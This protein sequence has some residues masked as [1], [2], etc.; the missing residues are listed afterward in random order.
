MGHLR[1]LDRLVALLLADHYA[2]RLQAGKHVDQRRVAHPHRA[3]QQRGTVA[4]IL[5][6]AGFAVL[7]EVPDPLHQ[8]RE[9][10]P[11]EERLTSGSVHR[12]HLVVPLPKLGRPLSS[13]ISAG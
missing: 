1:R 13:A 5:I 12:E 11:A 6:K 10:V 7:P 8:A 4:V 3:A 9:H 2:R